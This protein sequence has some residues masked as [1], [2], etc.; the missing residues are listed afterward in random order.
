MGLIE[1]MGEAM[2]Q[3]GDQTPA[4]PTAANQ[5]QNTVDYENSE[6]SNK[7]NN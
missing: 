1:N 2:K 7:Q 3:K 5:D 6:L 4:P